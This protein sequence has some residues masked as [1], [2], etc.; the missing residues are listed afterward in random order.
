MH[1]YGGPLEQL[2]PIGQ[3]DVKFI[4]PAGLDVLGG[5]AV[6]LDNPGVGQKK[7]PG[8]WIG[9]P[10]CGGQYVPTGQITLFG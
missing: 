4:D 9:L 7:L 8:H 5:H 6:G 2:Y 10:D 1:G 3:H